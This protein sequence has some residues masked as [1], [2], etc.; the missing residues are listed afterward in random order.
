M[1]YRRPTR[2]NHNPSIKP[3]NASESTSWR[4]HPHPQ[5]RV[6]IPRQIILDHL[7]SLTPSF[8]FSAF[9]CVLADPFFRGKKLVIVLSINSALLHYMCTRSDAE[10]PFNWT[11]IGRES[12]GGHP[13]VARLILCHRR[14]GDAIN[15]LLIVSAV[16]R[17]SG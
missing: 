15:Y 7:L 16:R 5:S 8:Y 14:R 17:V 1:V 6:H 2:I 10:I 3:F 13:I 4:L 9:F 11:K 12:P